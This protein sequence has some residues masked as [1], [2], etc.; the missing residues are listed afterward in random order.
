MV[1]RFHG[2]C[3]S[4]AN[5]KLCIVITITRETARATTRS[6]LLGGSVTQAVSKR[7]GVSPWP[8]GYVT[9]THIPHG[10][11]FVY[12]FDHYN[13]MPNSD[14]P[15][16]LWLYI[17]SYLPSSSFMKLMGVNRTFFNLALDA[18]YDEVRL[19]S[20]DL[21]T[22]HVFEQ[23]RYVPARSILCID[24]ERNTGMQIWPDGFAAFTCMRAFCSI[25]MTTNQ[26]KANHLLVNISPGYRGFGPPDHLLRSEE[27]KERQDMSYSRWQPSPSS[28]AVT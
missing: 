18:K 25:Q 11:E 4:I 9:V 10:K 22:L 23:L 20:S 6:S 26:R 5:K 14:L 13:A 2:L 7:C 17:L 1:A 16:E 24:T 12:A 28:N 19:V 21:R 27:I 15:T 8:V 3:M